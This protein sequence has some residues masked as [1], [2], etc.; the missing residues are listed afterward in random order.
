MLLHVALELRTLPTNELE[1]KHQKVTKS[2][3]L[4]SRPSQARFLSIKNRI[5]VCGMSCKF[6]GDE[7]NESQYNGA[8][9]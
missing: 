2:K 6:Y 1:Q 4:S 7:A 5:D 9:R 8:L 3:Q